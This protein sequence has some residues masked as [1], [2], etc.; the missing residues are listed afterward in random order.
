V[1]I[2]RRELL[3]MTALLAAAR[4]ARAQPDAP[5]SLEATVRRATDAIR[6]YSA[7]GNHRTATA[8]D[9]AS[10]NALL[11]RA[12][13]TGAS[14]SL[15]PFE[16]SRVHPGEAFLQI[17]DRRIEGLPMFDG[18]FTDAA[19]ISGRLGAIGGDQPIA[20]T[21]IPPNGEA[22]LRRVRDGSP[23]A[24][25][26]A[27]TM[28]G[29]PGLCPVN[30]GWFS[31]PFGPPV[32]QVSSE[33]LG[34]LET[35]AAAGLEIQVVA[36]ATRRRERAFN[37]VSEVRGTDP[38]LAPICVMT[39]RSG[40]HANASERGG[41]LVCWLEVMRAVI[42]SRGSA[43]AGHYRNGSMASGA[44]RTV[45]FVASSGHELGHLGLHDYLRRNP[46][47][48]HRAYAWVHFGANIGASTGDV[49]MTASDDRLRDETLRI[50][51]PHGLDQIRQA[52]AAQVAGEAATIKEE[53][54]RFVSFIGRNDWFH[55][56]RDLWPDAVDV[57]AVARFARAAAD[58]TLHLASTA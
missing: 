30:A 48:A 42:T 50:F 6:A 54:G 51:A 10:A 31:E 12:R 28:G 5:A 32:L 36:S 11:V 4:A 47:L 46:T 25:I 33:H 38:A 19:G 34:A 44:R 15:E 56:P 9:L 21:R 27:V 57:Q 18:A 17:R 1:P 49:G 45:K 13:A 23:H 22:V 29:K 20:W 16:L 40:W 26:V 55:N 3:E 39:P 58:L 37:V 2:T 14:A 8:V 53:D 43:E 24:A 35:A 41:G 7:E 52:P